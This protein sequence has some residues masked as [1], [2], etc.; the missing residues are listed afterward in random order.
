MLVARVEPERLHELRRRVLRNNDPRVSVSDARDGDADAMHLA[1]L[2]DDRV[3]ACGSFYPSPTPFP[4]SGLAYQLRYLATDQ[5]LQGQHLGSMLLAAADDQLQSRGVD[6]LWANGRD[7]ALGFY[8]RQG[9]ERLA[10]SE[11][12]SAETKLPHTVIFKF[13][14]NLEPVVLDEISADDVDALMAMR[15]LMFFSNQLNDVDGPWIVNF[16]PHF[17]KGVAADT[18]RGVVMRDGQGR[19]V[20]SALVDLLQGLP[21]RS[22]PRGRTA[23]VHTVVT[24]APFRR[25]GLS[26]HLLAALLE[27]IVDWDVD[28]VDLHATKFGEDLY[29]EFGFA[30]RRTGLAMRAQP[31]TA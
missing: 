30:E 20:A 19:I 8:D 3:V 1:V 11:H 22:T 25:R 13:L 26:R 6:V 15:R 27:R 31:P 16:R 10:G 28:A 2:D 7:T 24:R 23:Y 17:L 21:M 4:S 18:T 5:P 12:L 29:R 14:R 9:W